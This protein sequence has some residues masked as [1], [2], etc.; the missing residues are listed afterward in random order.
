[1]EISQKVAYLK[2]L[3]E[4]QDL[5]GKLN[6]QVVADRLLRE[7]HPETEPAPLA[8]G[9]LAGRKDLLAQTLGVELESF[10][11]RRRPW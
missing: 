10:L 6:D 4:V 8:S 7:L 3:A 9:W 11:S 5:L 2:G 1:M